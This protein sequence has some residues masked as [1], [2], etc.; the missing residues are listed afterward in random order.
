MKKRSPLEISNDKPC[1]P[2]FLVGAV[3]GSL[4]IQVDGCRKCPFLN[5]SLGGRQTRLQAR[6]AIQEYPSQYKP[7]GNWSFIK[8]CPLK[9]NIVS[10]S[11]KPNFP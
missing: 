6:C 4:T 11:P 10:V 2:A 8:T 3:T 1:R 7:D 5:T 9:E